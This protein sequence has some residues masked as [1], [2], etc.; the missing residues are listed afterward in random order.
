[1]KI[2]WKAIWDANPD[3]FIVSGWEECSEEKRK[4]WHLCSHYSYFSA[5]DMNLRVGIIA[6]QGTYKEEEFLAEGIVWGNRLGNGARTVIYF[7]AQDFS[8]VFLGALAKLGGAFSGKA[9][10]FREKLMPCLYPVLER[11]YFKNSYHIEPGEIRAGWDFWERQLNPVAYNHLRIIKNYF[12]GLARRRVRV[13]FD[14]N[15]IFFCW[16]K[17]EIAE[18]KKK[19]NK[20]EL[21]TKVKWTRN[22]SIASKF[23]K[24]G[25]VDCSDCLNEE[26]CRAVNGI[27]ELLENMESNGCLDIQDLMAL[28]IINDKEFIL[29]NFGKYFDFPWLISDRSDKYELSNYYFF[30]Q[31]TEICVI[32]PILEKPLLKVV[33]SLLAYTALEYIN[34]AEQGIP[35]E[36]KLKWNRSI[37]LLAQ[38]QLRDEMRLCQTWL[39]KSDIFPIVLLPEDWQTEGFKKA[40]GLTV[41]DYETSYF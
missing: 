4:G 12:S 20:F 17:I 23:L 16:G 26:F 38:P 14:K 31:G 22:K 7:V 36:P 37:T 5:G 21:T 2:D 28:R 19:G 3:L 18:L 27:L 40:K 34:L 9:V 10:Y 33:N 6:S 11:N 25:W 1:M 30:A 24:T 41:L 29:Q 15:K 8:P 13:V 39:K 32:H 35:G